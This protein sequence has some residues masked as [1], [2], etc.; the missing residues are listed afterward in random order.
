MLAT[1]G[2]DFL[3]HQGRRQCFWW[4]SLPGQ[5]LGG[6]GELGLEEAKFR[7][8]GLEGTGWRKQQERRPVGRGV[9]PQCQAGGGA[10][11]LEQ[12]GLT[13]SR[14]VLMRVCDKLFL[15]AAG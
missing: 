14:D 6:L 12:W 3:D 9:R 1:Q 5:G 7:V 11:L 2:D 8:S 13:G 10:F 4:G 15:A